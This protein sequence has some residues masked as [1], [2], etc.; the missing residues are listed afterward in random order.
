[1]YQIVYQGRVP[2]D[3]ETFPEGTERSRVGSLPLVPRAGATI[4][5]EEL[6]ALEAAK[7]PFKIIAS[8]VAEPVA[9]ALEA[10]APAAKKPRKR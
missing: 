2:L 7:V 6:A 3:F 4:T 8:P 5:A 1:M 9:P 10:Q